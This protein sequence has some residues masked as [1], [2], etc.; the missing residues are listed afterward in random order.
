MYVSRI[1]N[2]NAN[3]TWLIRES[4]WGD[5][6]CKKRTLANITRLPAHIRDDIQRLLKGGLVVD[7]LLDAFQAHYT[8]TRRLPHGPVLCALGSL[9]K[10]KLEGL[11]EP[12]PSR[13]RRIAVALVV[14]RILHPRS[15][16][17][18]L[19]ALHGD[20]R[21]SSLSA[22][23]KLEDIEEHE[24]YA[25][26]DWLYDRKEAIERRL[27]RQHL[28]E[29]AAVLCDISST[30]VEGHGADLAEFGYSRDGK[31][32][33]R[34]INFSLLC[35]AAGRPVAVK[36]FPGRPADPNT[37]TAQLDTLQKRFGLSRAILGGDR[38]L[39]TSARLREA[40]RPAGYDWITA[41]RKPALRKLARQKAIQRSL[42]DET[43]LAESTS[44]AY[45]GERLIVCR[46]P[47]RADYAAEERQRRL[48]ATE[49]ALDKLV[50]ATQRKRR[51]L[52]GEQ[53]IA[54]KA[55]AALGQRK[56]KKHFTWTITDTSFTYCR[57]EEA[58]ALEASLD[59]LYVV[60]TS[61]K[62]DALPAEE[63]VATYKQLS[64]V[65]AAF[66]SIKTMD[67]KVRP[68]YHYKAN[69]IK[70]HLFL[71][72][73]AYYVMGHMKQRLA[74][75]L[76]AEEDLE[77]ATRASVVAPRQPS[78]AP[79]TKV[80]TKTPRAGG[81]ALSFPALMDHM[82]LLTKDELQAKDGGKAPVGLFTPPTKLQAQALKLLGVRLK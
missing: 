45:P 72:M 25:A 80:R 47:L 55:G 13:M 61:V 82:A 37:L 40:V 30:Y 7:D 68:I 24:V 50:Q 78:T 23:L 81:R 49:K 62:K 1:P 39:L 70:S 52:R 20:S 10:L 8:G 2:R 75:M 15:K 74:P 63:A 4:K 57:D 32:G 77:G 5:G 76:Y 54:L 42:F 31:K 65:E 16:R 46:N 3:P 12:V 59:G 29:G 21:S 53:A 51:P 69:R 66:R 48:L 43:D 56:M 67:L 14:R 38:G 11:I 9:K 71:C 73:L 64:V 41:L 36:V 79:K 26:M 44:D 6:T 28:T 58:I 22:E 34:Q 17:A 35:D 19:D 27:A 33:K 18:P 60:R